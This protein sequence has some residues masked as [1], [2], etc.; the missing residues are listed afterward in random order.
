MLL[1]VINYFNEE[2]EEGKNEIIVRYSTFEEKNLKLKPGSN[3]RVTYH[4][5]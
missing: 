4:N 1:R 5:F 2:V 3:G